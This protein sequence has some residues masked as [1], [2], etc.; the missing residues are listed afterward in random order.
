MLIRITDDSLLKRN[1]TPTRSDAIASAVLLK[2]CGGRQEAGLQSIYG[3]MFFCS[4]RLCTSRVNASI[5]SLISFVIS[6][7]LVFCSSKIT[8]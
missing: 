6:V 2:D 7:N 1:P 3:F 4:N 8:S 5:R